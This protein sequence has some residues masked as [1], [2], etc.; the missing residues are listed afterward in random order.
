MQCY[1]E[2][3]EDLMRRYYE[4]LNERDRRRY[5]GMG[6]LILGHGGQNYIAK[7]LGCSKKTVRKGAVEVAKLPLRTV[8]ELIGKVPDEHPKIR[9]AGEDGNRIGFPTRK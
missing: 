8:Q 6:A 2:K 3:T 5:A 9:N 7:I 1:P 4:S